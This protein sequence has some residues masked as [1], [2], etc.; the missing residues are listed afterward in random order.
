LIL[1]AATSIGCQSSQSRRTIAAA[2]PSLLPSTESG[3]VVTGGRNTTVVAATPAREV[4]W[5][6]RHPLFTK[7][8]EYYENSGKNKVVKAT[9]ATVIGIPAGFFGE[10]KQI[11]VGAPPETRY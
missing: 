8:R 7:P 2:E 11:V 1:L 9:A 10:M 6:D 4:T 3:T 5:A